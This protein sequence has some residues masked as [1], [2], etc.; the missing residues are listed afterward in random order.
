MEDD[1][2]RSLVQEFLAG[3]D[4]AFDT[5]YGELGPIIRAAIARKTRLQDTDLDDLVQIVFTA[6]YVGREVCSY[7]PDRGPFLP[8]FRLYANSRVNDELRAWN[9]RAGR[10]HPFEGNTRAEDLL[11]TPDPAD[12]VR[13]E[14]LEEELLAALDRALP[15]LT[16]QERFVINNWEGALG[17]L[18][19]N[20]IGRRLGLCNSRITT[21]KQ[22]ALAKLAQLMGR[23]WPPP[24]SHSHPDRSSNNLCPGDS[25]ASSAFR[26][27]GDSPP[28]SE[29]HSPQDEPTGDDTELSGR[30]P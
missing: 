18:P 2:A 11:A 16:A 24:G 3:N 20:E 22:S 9:R 27:E 25:P 17:S 5:L 12:Q 8:W 19:Q 21:I 13:K 4:E 30:R 6:F 14:I 29:T 1:R 26:E 23:T 15:E 10:H 28:F 7:D